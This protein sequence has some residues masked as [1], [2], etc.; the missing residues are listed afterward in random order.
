MPHPATAQLLQDLGLARD[1]HFASLFSVYPQPERAPG[2]EGKVDQLDPELFAGEEIGNDNAI[3]RFDW[4]DL[5]RS[6]A[7]PALRMPMSHRSRGL[8]SLGPS[9]TLRASCL[10]RGLAVRSIGAGHAPFYRPKAVNAS[11]KSMS[12]VHA[13]MYSPVYELQPITS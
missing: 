6:Q 8:H 5:S 4:F 10:C 3:M 2:G 12:S 7:A 11:K 13:E 1:R 9:F